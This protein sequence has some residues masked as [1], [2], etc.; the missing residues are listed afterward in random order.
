MSLAAHATELRPPAML[1][2][3]P[4]GLAF[5]AAERLRDVIPHWI[6]APEAQVEGVRSSSPERHLDLPSGLNATVSHA[7]YTPSSKGDAWVSLEGLY[8]EAQGIS[9]ND[10]PSLSLYLLEAHTRQSA[11]PRYARKAEGGGFILGGEKHLI[12]L[13]REPD[14][15]VRLCLLE[16]DKGSVSRLSFLGRHPVPAVFRGRSFWRGSGGL[17][18]PPLHQCETFLVDQ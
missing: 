18:T 9:H 13:C 7:F 6:N 10:T 3:M 16:P 8:R 15:K 17:A 1:L 4:E 11:L 12:P 2:H 5:E 14:P